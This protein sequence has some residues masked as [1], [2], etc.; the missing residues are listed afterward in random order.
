VKYFRWVL[1]IVFFISVKDED[2]RVAFFSYR[3]FSESPLTDKR[4]EACEGTQSMLEELNA[5]SGSQKLN[6]DRQ[7]SSTWTH[8]TTAYGVLPRGS[9]SREQKRVAQPSVS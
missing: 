5:P 6:G 3:L 8:G 1:I 7:G 9:K 2:R 4:I